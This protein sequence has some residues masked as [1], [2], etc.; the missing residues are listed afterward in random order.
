MKTSLSK[1]SVII[2]VLQSFTLSSNKHIPENNADVNKLK[3]SFTV[4][5]NFSV[6][7]FSEIFRFRLS[8]FRWIEIS[9]KKDEDGSQTSILNYN[10]KLYNLWICEVRFSKPINNGNLMTVQMSILIYGLMDF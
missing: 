4:E 7:E 3:Y 6:A 8:K 5:T 10:D 1:I 2:L 9:S